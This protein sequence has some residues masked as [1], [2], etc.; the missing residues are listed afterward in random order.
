MSKRRLVSLEDMMNDSIEVEIN[1]T[2]TRE[3]GREEEE[4][5]KN[6]DLTQLSPSN[7]RLE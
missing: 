4:R 1:L 7:K 6:E 3:N 5:R 2:A